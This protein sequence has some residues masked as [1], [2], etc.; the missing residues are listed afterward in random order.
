MFVAEKLSQR[1]SKFN[2]NPVALVGVSSSF[3]VGFAQKL[4]G[5]VVSHLGCGAVANGGSLASAPAVLKFMLVFYVSTTW[6]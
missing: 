4:A 3:A 5:I 1:Q 6:Q 2:G